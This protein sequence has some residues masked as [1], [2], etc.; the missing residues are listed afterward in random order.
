MKSIILSTPNKV[1]VVDISKPKID[2]YRNVL[3]KVAYC[4]ICGSDIPKFL[5]KRTTTKDLVMGHEFCGWVVDG[6]QHLI[7]QL[8]TVI[9]LWYCDKCT[10][11]KN[12]NYQLCENQLFMGST[13]DGGLQEYVTVPECY[14]Y[15]IPELVQSPK[16]GALI[17][18]LS[19]AVH[20]V[21]LLYTKNLTY[22]TIGIVGYGS[23]G[24]LIKLVLMQHLGVS[25]SQIKIINPNTVLPDNTLDYCY[26]CSGSVGG[27]NSAIKFTKFRGTI[28]QIGIIY[29]HKLVAGDLQFDKL[30]RKEQIL[31]GSWNSDF[32]EDWRIA[33]ELIKENIDIYNSIVS[34]VFNI[35][36][37][38]EAFETKINNTTNK[39]LI[40]LEKED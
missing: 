4:G 26:E 34:Y 25:E 6:P 16:L 21:D 19:C 14:L 9:P 35:E 36:K 11:C 18:P 37:A 15:P 20:A 30:L 2:R 22:K 29:P 24:S 23:I 3:I 7:N 31:I 40:K 13:I 27:L 32:H 5:G 8:V 1:E 33:Y 38:Q 39:V 17:E 28:V 12:G 10:N